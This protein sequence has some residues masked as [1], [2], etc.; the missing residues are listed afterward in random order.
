M[1]EIKQIGEK[2]LQQ[3]A[4]I[5]RDIGSKKELIKDMIKIMRDNKGIGIAAPQ[6]GVS[7][8][9]VVI[10]I[11]KNER[12][13]DA[14]PYPFTVMINPEIE[15]LTDEVE[16]GY[17]GCLSVPG[18][19]GIVPRCKYVRVKYLDESGSIKEDILESF[20]AKV[21]QHEIDHLEGIVFIERVKDLKT[22]ITNENYFKYITNL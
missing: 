4:E 22:L 14:A 17:E 19:R 5:V 10:E 9:V 11:D 18:I 3:K 21:V 6:V 15:Y 1:R 7:E 8:R 20:P 2:I 16:E 13:P 12:Y